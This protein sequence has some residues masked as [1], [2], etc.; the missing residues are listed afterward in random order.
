VLLLHVLV[1]KLQ[2]EEH[3][4]KNASSSPSPSASFT[5]VKNNKSILLDKEKRIAPPTRQCLTPPDVPLY[6]CLGSISA[7]G[8]VFYIP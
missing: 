1:V 7:G 4:G 3:G 2:N 6:G 8:A 5:I